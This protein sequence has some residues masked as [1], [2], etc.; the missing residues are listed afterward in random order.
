MDR[1]DLAAVNEIDREAFPT[2]WPPPNYRHELQNRLAHYIV[3]QDDSRKETRSSKTDKLPN[4]ML[5]W[6]RLPWLKRPSTSALRQTRYYIVGF[7]G[8]WLLTDEAHITNL[9]VREAHR[10]RGLG[11]LLLIATADLAASLGASIMTL[12]VR[13]SNTVAR[14]LYLKYGFNET[15]LRKG[16]YLDNRE[17]AIIMTTD[18]ITSDAYRQL[19]QSLRDSLSSRLSS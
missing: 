4:G 11:E 6:L 14:N 16:Y 15:G 9:A 10:G 17:D 12:E 8:I 1:D 13:A 7:A 3:A 2:Q 19:L 18:K 5:V